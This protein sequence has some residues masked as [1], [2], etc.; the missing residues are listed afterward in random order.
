MI[1]E[2]K[3][4]CSYVSDHVEIDDDDDDDDDGDGD[5]NV[6]TKRTKAMAARVTVGSL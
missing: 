5:A 6:M 4:S 1:D 2:C 3:A